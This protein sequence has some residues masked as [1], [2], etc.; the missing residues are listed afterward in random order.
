MKA[1]LNLFISLKTNFPPISE[2][3]NKIYKFIQN[4]YVLTKWIYNSLFKII[5]MLSG[6]VK[7]N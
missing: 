5:N 3:Q 2:R 4:Q 1:V 7:T 6:K